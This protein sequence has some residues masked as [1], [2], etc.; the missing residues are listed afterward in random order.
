MTT[1]GQKRRV[2]DREQKAKLDRQQAEGLDV[3]HGGEHD[4]KL[5]AVDQKIEDRHGD[6]S[7]P[8][9]PE[10]LDSLELPKG[11]LIAFRKSGGLRFSSHHLVVYPDGRVTHEGGDTA[12]TALESRARRKLND[13]QIVRMRKLLDQANFWNMPP[14]VG[15]QSPDAFAYELVA[16]IGNKHHQSEMFDGSVPDSMQPLIEQMNKLMPSDEE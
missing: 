2:F 1:P 11:A 10:T 13:A 7:A 14:T 16:R 8:P 5:E 9:P 6:K 4:S 3:P 12:K 15:K